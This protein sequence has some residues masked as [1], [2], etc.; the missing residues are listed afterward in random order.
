MARAHLHS[1]SVNQLL[2]QVS[3]LVLALVAFSGLSA[4]AQAASMRV[5]GSAETAVARDALGNET[6]GK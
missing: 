2:R 6:Y 3:Q 1:R 4:S 5:T